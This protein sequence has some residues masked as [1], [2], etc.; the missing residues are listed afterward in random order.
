MCVCVSLYGYER[1]WVCVCLQLMASTLLACIHNVQIGLDCI[2][3]PLHV[4]SLLLIV[5]VTCAR[6]A[7]GRSAVTDI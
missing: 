1:A 3:A 4:D 5:V 2:A 6:D 7:M